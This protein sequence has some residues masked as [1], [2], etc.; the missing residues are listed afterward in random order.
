LRTDLE[1][2]RQWI[3]GEFLV[4]LAELL[5]LLLCPL[6]RFLRAHV[7]HFQHFRECGDVLR[8]ERHGLRR[9]ASHEERDDLDPFRDAL[10][11]AAE[12]ERDQRVESGREEG[13]A[14]RGDRERRKPRR[15]AEGPKCLTGDELHWAI[16][17]SGSSWLS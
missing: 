14:D 3:A 5:Q 11:R 12:V 2:G 15:T 1:R 13:E 10:E 16:S 6:E 9:G 8:G 7:I 4:R 17:S